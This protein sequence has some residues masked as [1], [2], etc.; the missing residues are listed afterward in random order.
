MI[1]T[2]IIPKNTD[3]LLSIPKKYI[4]KQ[5]EVLVY[6]IDEI[7]ESKND[8][9]TM[10]QYK[11]MLSKKAGEAFLKYTEKSRKEWDKNS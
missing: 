9:N 6:A 4:G 8:I 10:S 11:G 2:S 7:N 3:I 5:V 1:K